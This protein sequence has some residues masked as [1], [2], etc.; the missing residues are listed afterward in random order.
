MAADAGDL[1]QLRAIITSHAVCTF[2][3][4]YCVMHAVA[5]TS[6]LDSLDDC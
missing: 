2:K 1:P 4:M 3:M 6:I 5:T